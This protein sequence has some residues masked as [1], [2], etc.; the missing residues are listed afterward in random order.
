[1]IQHQAGG[2]AL[3]AVG[4]GRVVKVEPGDGDSGATWKVEVVTTAGERR[5]VAGSS[6]RVILKNEPGG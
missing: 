3:L 4:G 1:M 2:F 5:K 6:H